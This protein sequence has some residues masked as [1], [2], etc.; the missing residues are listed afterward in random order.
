MKCSF[1][2]QALRLSPHEVLRCGLPATALHLNPTA[3][4]AAERKSSTGS[5]AHSLRT[6]PIGALPS[7]ADAELGCN[8]WRHGESLCLYFRLKWHP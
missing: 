7:L 6:G 2:G 4:Y 8:I 1:L 3:A 5:P